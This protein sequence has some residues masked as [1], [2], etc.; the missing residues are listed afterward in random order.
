M[1]QRFKHIDLTARQERS[2][3]FEGGIFGRGA[4]QDHGPVLHSPQ[5]RV[6]LGFVEAVYLVNEKYWSTVYGEHT[7]AFG[8]VYD[9][10]DILDSAAYCREGVELSLQRV[11]HNLGYGCLSDTRRAPKDKGLDVAAFNHTAQHGIFAHEMLLTDIFVKRVRTQTF[12]Q[13]NVGR[14]GAGVFP[15]SLI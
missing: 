2:Y 5:K 3:H 14:G 1:F 15:I 7:G 13:R 9:I 4:N 10:P 8:L 11:C 12:G 6:L